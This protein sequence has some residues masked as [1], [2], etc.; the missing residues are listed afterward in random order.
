[1]QLSKECALKHGAIRQGASAQ[2]HT[3]CSHKAMV[4]NVHGLAS[5]ARLVQVDAV[6]ENLRA[7]SRK[8]AECSNFHLVGAIDEMAAGDGGVPLHNQTATCA[9]GPARNDGSGFR[10]GRR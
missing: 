1:M 6:G 3:A 7:E 2:Q 8:R 10:E 5:L 9:P 4:A